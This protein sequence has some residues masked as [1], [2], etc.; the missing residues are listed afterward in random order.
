MTAA[1][2]PVQ[3]AGQVV[4]VR[5]TGAYHHLTL[6][7]PGVVERHRPGAQVALTVGGALS[8]AMLRRAFPVHRARP[9]G[10]H[11]GTL[12]L[13]VEAAD[14]AT[15]WLSETVA[16]TPLDVI[17]PVGRPFALPKEPVTCVLVVDGP[18]GAGLFLLAERLRERRCVVHMLLGG[19]T[20]AHLLGVLEARRT[21]RSLTVATAD[22]S[23]GARGSAGE[24][25]PALL[26]RTRA[27]VVYAGGP[28]PLLHAVA[29]AAEEHGAWSQTAVPWP[30]VCGTGVCHGCA[31]PV[32][33][34]DGIAR[35]ARACVDGPVFR[36]D[37]VRWADLATEE[38]AT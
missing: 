35:T 24:A 27:D 4:G 7:A 8:A 23:V 11:G 5:R 22:G 28:V 16:G 3:V 9:A 2:G 36:G 14:P 33:G 15:R 37:R 18:G 19:R 1:T 10:P 38:V 34:E 31:V 21:A 17:G 12:E 25:L 26:V 30:A 20:E 29:R 32:V 13:V 6:L